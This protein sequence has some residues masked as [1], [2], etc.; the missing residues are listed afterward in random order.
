ML[1]ACLASLVA[2]SER[3]FALGEQWELLVVDDESTDETAAIAAEFAQDRAGVVVMTPPAL[4]AEGVGF[5]GKNNACWAAAQRARGEWLLFTD[6]DTVHEP[7]DLSR[8]L[9]E[10]ERHQAALLSYS[11]RQVV[12]GFW[13]RVV[14][15]L[16]FSEL[17]SVYPP[18]QVSDPA[19]RTGGS[20]WAVSAGRARGVLRG[21]RTSGSRAR[22][23]GGCGAGA[24]CEAQHRCK[25]QGA[26]HSVPLCA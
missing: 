10:A 13:Q 14:M 19:S 25:R 12:T 6:A 1:G 11:P 24:D 9:H 5:T 21:G 7:G 22:G 3:G 16:V 4:G 26:G 20:E 17:A 15:P 23:A 18:N 2:Q 8:A